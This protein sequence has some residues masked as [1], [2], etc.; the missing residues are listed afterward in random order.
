MEI[1]R[2]RE[3]LG[4]HHR[5][6]LATYRSDGRPQLTPV[7]AGIDEEGR[8]VISATETRAKVRNLR[9]DPRA[10]L[11]TM[12]DSFFGGW[13]QVDGTAEIASLPEAMEL[14]VDYYRRLAGEHPNWDEYRE[15]MQEE[16]RCLIR[17]QI[18]G[19]AG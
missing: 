7:L 19:A 3:F 4:E 5:S 18:E 10:S 8:V 17:I 16:Q 14:L 9:R 12:T 6:V 1:K 15:R 13:V 11:C 2:A